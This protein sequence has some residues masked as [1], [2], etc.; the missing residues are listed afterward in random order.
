MS[1]GGDILRILLPIGDAWPRAVPELVRDQVLDGLGL[2][3]DRVRRRALDLVEESDPRTAI[4]MLPEWEAA[5]GLPDTCAPLA[6]T[7]AERQRRA[8]AKLIARGGDTIAY[9]TAVA[10][11]LGF[12]ITIEEHQAATCES[13]CEAALD[14]D[15]LVIDGL[16]APWFTV[17]DIRAPAEIVFELDCLA[18]GCDEPLAWWG[19]EYFECVMRREIR[20]RR[21]TRHLYVRFAYGEA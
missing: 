5:L 1:A 18:G 8:H 11:A 12:A 16:P 9:F 20:R 2:S 14:P 15:D 6:D 10:A 21:A 4:E 3:Y 13:D 17:I 19:N 7:V